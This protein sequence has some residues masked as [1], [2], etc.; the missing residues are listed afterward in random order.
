LAPQVAREA[1]NPIRCAAHEL[2]QLRVAPIE[3]VGRRSRCASD[4]L[5]DIGACRDLLVKQ[6][7]RF[8]IGLRRE[9]G[10]GLLCLLAYLLRRFAEF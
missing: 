5:H 4:L 3:S 8:L 9:R 1:I 7:S 10:S 2:G 6:A